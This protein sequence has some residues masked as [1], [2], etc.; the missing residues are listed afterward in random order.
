MDLLA[1]RKFL[2]VGAGFYGAVWAHELAKLGEEVLVI[3]KRTHIGGNCFSYVDPQTQ[4]NVHKY[5]SHIFHTQDKKIWDYV[6]NFTSFNHYRHRVFARYQNRTYSLP[7]NLDTINSFYQKNFSPDEARA[8]LALEILKGQN[9]SPKNLEEKAISQIGPGLYQ[10]FIRGYTEKQWGRRATELPESIINRLPVRYNYNAFYFDDPYQGIPLGGYTP[11]FEKMLAS[12][13]IEVKLGVDFQQIKKQVPEK[14]WVI[15]SGPLDAFF[16]YSLGELSWRT[17]DFEEEVLPQ[18]DFQGNS[19]INYAESSVPYTRIHE[20]KHYHPEVSHTHS[21]TFIMRE[22]SRSA[23]RQDTPYYP[24][25][26]AA[27]KAVL[28]KYMEKTKEHPQVIFGGR[29]GSYKYF[30]MHQVIGQAL[31]HIERWKKLLGS[32]A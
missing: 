11:I 14:T 4:I 25:N 5:G 31:A 8:F 12:P 24:V 32:N 30:D 23:G 28:D 6:N 13:K 20:F 16:D 1:G 15:Y 21:Q 29:L 10:A 2:I 22:F 27:D 3:D 26:A 17:L 19:V 9:A 18:A 7:I